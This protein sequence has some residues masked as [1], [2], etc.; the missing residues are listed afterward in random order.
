MQYCIR[1]AAWLLKKQKKT[2]TKNKTL[3][4]VKKVYAG[5]PD[6]FIDEHLLFNFFISDY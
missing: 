3:S 1:S 2:S 4:S 5:V 6:G